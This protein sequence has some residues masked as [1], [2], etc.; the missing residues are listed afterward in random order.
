M[1]VDARIAVLNATSGAL[2]AAP[3]A[4]AADLIRCAHS[5][6]L[7]RDAISWFGTLSSAHIL[8]EEQLNGTSTRSLALVIVHCD[9]Y[10]VRKA[11]PLIFEFYSWLMYVMILMFSGATACERWNGE[12]WQWRSLP[13]RAL[14]L[15]IIFLTVLWAVVET[16]VDFLRCAASLL[17]EQSEVISRLSRLIVPIASLCVAV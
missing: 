14:L 13:S 8:C 5:P 17:L 4:G 12:H 10:A 3:P 2:K 16:P 6:F 1:L 9:A 7:G 15:C 11:D